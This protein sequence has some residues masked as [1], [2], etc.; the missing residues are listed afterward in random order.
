MS[1]RSG[2]DNFSEIIYHVNFNWVTRTAD[3]IQILTQHG[4]MQQQ[5]NSCV[6][7]FSYIIPIYISFTTMDLFIETSKSF[8][9]EL[10]GNW[11]PQIMCVLQR[12]FFTLFPLLWTKW[13]WTS[14]IHPVSFLRSFCKPLQLL[15]LFTAVSNLFVISKL[16]HTTFPQT[17]TCD[18]YYIS[19]LKSFNHINGNT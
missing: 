12:V 2:M 17:I 18:E 8:Y 6:L 3:S 1:S 10:T 9:R 14:F 4:F 11:E 16:C 13:H 15:P 19:Q 5:S 7:C